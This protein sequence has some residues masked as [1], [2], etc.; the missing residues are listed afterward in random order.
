M[1]RTPFKHAFF[2][3]FIKSYVLFTGYLNQF[4]TNLFIFQN[5]RYKKVGG[6]FLLMK[7]QT[8]LLSLTVISLFFF[9]NSSFSQTLELGTLTSFD[10]FAGVGAVTNNGTSSGD[11][12]TNAGIISGSGFETANGYTG[13]IHKNDSLSKQAKIDLLRIYIH[14][15]DV[16]VDFPST[17]APAFGSGE[18]ITSGVYSTG[19]AGSIAGALTL[20][21]EGDSDAFFIIKFEG[22]FTV[23]TDSSVTLINGARASNVF[24]IS[25][26]AI[27][28][29]ARSAIKGTLF[30]HPGAVTLGVN[31]T[32]EGR[33]LTSEGAI[34]V[35]AGGVVELPTGP[36]SI[37]I[38]CLSNCSPA[39]AVDVL[40]SLSSF[41]LFTSQ[42]A[43]AN[44]ATSGMVGDIGTHDGAI[45][46]FG[47]STHVGEY[48]NANT[49]TEQAKIDLQNAYEKL[50]ALPNTITGH[51]PAFGTGETITTGVYYINGAGSLAGTITLD[52]QN[53]PDAIFVFKFNGAFSVAAQSRVILTNLT[54]RCNVFWISE[55]AA[56]MGTFTYMKGTVIANK[57]ACTMGA[58]GSM[59][60]RM[61]STGGAIGFSTGVL[62]NDTLCFEPRLTASPDTPTTPENTVLNVVAADGVLKN[63]ISSENYPLKIKK[64]TV[65][66]D[67]YLPGNTATLLQGTLKINLDGGYV[68]TPVANFNGPV[69]TVTYTVTDG[70]EEASSTLVITVTAINNPPV[71]NPDAGITD[72]DTTLV[73]SA[74]DGLLTN[75]TDIEN[76]VLSI[77]QFTVNGTPYAPGSDGVMPEGTIKINADGSYDFIPLL[78]YNGTVP[79]IDYTITD[80]FDTTSSAL[81]IEVKKVNDAPVA[82]DDVNETF[83]GVILTVAANGV[84]KNDSDVDGDVLNLS[85]FVVSGT[86]GTI[87]L[88]GETATILGEGTLKINANGSYVFTPV[89]DFNGEV[90]QATYTITDGFLTTTAKLDITVNGSN[91]APILVPDAII[92]EEDATTVS[93]DVAI[94]L[95][96]NDS[97][98]DGDILKVSSFTILGVTVIVQVTGGVRII[99]NIGT[100]K[101]NPDGSYDFTPAPNYN[102]TVPTVTYTVTDGTNTA[103]S[104]LTITVTSVNDKP[105]ATDDTASTNPSVPVNI[106][107]LIN[108]TDVDG[109][110]LNINAIT[111]PPSNGTAVISDNGTPGDASDDFV[112]YEPNLGFNIG[113]DTFTYQVSDGNLISN[114]AVVTITVP[115]GNVKPTANPDTNATDEDI[116]LVV[117]EGDPKNLLSNDTDA[118]SDDLTVA[119]FDIEGTPYNAGDEAIFIDGSKLTVTIVGGYTFTPVENFNGPVPV[120]NYTITDSSG[121]S[122]ASTLNITVNPIN[123]APIALPDTGTTPEDTTLSVNSAAG[124]LFNDS[125]IDGDVLSII[126]FNIRTVSYTA[127]FTVNLIEG[128]ITI[129]SDGS[130]TFIP[131]GDFNAAVPQVTYTITDGI[132]DTVT[133]TLDITVGGEN[134]APVAIDDIGN[135]TPEDTSITIANIASNDTDDGNVVASTIVLIDPVNPA[136]IG[137]TANPLPIIGVGLYVIDPSGNVIFT[138]TA[139][140]NGVADINYTIEDDEGLISNEGTIKLTVEALN[141]VPVAQADSNTTIEGVTLTVSAADGVLSND[142]DVENDPLILTEFRIGNDIYP[143]GSDVIIAE[144]TLQIN[145]D[146]SYIFSPAADYD[147]PVPQIIYTLS[148]GAITTTTNATLDITVTPVNDKPVANPDTN[149]VTEN[150]QLNVSAVNGVLSNDTDVDNTSLNVIQFTIYSTD[151]APGDTASFSEG[152]LQINSDGGYVF[153]PTENYT[154]EVSQVTYTI[155]DGQL[156]ATST[157]DISVKAEN[158][159]PV[160]VNDVATTAENVSIT[161]ALIT[162]NDTDADGTIDATTIE[163]IDPDD[164]QN[165]GN[166]TTSLVILNKGTYTIDALGNV[167]LVPILDFIGDANINYTVKDNTGIISNVATISITVE[168]D[169]DEDSTPDT[170]DLDDDN[171]GIPDLTEEN[172]YAKQNSNSKQKGNLNRDTDADG[173][174]DYLDLDSDGDGVSDLRESGSGAADTNNDGVI[175]GSDIGSGTNGLFDGLEETADNGILN[176]TPTDTDTNGIPDFQDLDDDGDGVYTA[177]EDINT[178]E[179][180]TNDDTD[181]DGVPNYLDPDDDDDGIPTI[182]EFFL[183]CDEDNI[184]DHLDLTNCN[185]IPNAFSPNG[186]GINDTFLVQQLAD[187]LDFKLEIFNRW[188]T[189]VYNYSN[190][191]KTN[192]DWWNGFSSAK[193]TF[194]NSKALP[195]GTYYYIIDYNNGI[196]KPIAGWVY[197][198][199]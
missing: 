79:L 131:S 31:S 106:F 166:S 30:A 116:T 167:N 24:W 114:T 85:S 124:L 48:H 100:L 140:Y 199:R 151:Y 98:I 188:G 19:G 112:S 145:S 15:D 178:D 143:S 193:L 73:V 78:N 154:G 8:A 118:N 37:P 9:S 168:L 108:D 72:E 157:L 186:D 17:H 155:S 141:D 22:A 86:P 120:V 156:D 50:I 76:D 13:T 23:G 146:G 171:D 125:D 110:T 144:G 148:D 152:A 162:A 27:S 56:S 18:T 38:S 126:G 80:G 67:T 164:S 45:S 176:Y 52:G 159:A 103:N 104:S 184:P 160:A 174:P 187:Y 28:V 107:V 191:G 43:V 192:P 68:F 128:S 99:P 62:Y 54:R 82:V 4:I 39:A 137:N 181:A 163:L 95:L 26:G 175:D 197:L 70:A 153:T 195:V 65:N 91:D 147:G 46:G 179:D 132:I 51:T 71:A 109:D 136:N 21:G 7:K 47:T 81:R 57:G 84:L 113:T 6:Y 83:E 64:F 41:G 89:P 129:N 119:S 87:Y 63:D 1:I 194:N 42:G 115:D 102:G 139:N 77:T 20:D 16:F 34:T 182:D 96:A 173:I 135:E 49:V 59:E 36:I 11:A 117:A 40:G 55:G 10:L 90:A 94:G 138:P 3:D 142:L 88:A 2:I 134:D 97:D 185:I 35:E 133:S 53:N 93:V 170:A 190:N 14:I 12:G 196:R 169:T 165:I 74:T 58:N 111:S 198:N 92:V 122:D 66:G 75:D 60:G 101:I 105:S 69:A 150:T 127:G 189:K 25:Q 61:L 183:D 161:I 44:A 180:A 149:T 5:K 177:D 33:L 130:Y 29:G 158:S 172:N 121:A 32:I 123:D